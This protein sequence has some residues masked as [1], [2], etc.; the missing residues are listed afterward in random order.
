MKHPLKAYLISVFL[1]FGL[2]PHNVRAA[3]EGKAPPAPPEKPPLKIY[4]GFPFKKGEI[5][6]MEVTYFGANAGYVE[7]RVL[8][9]AFLGGRWMMGFSALVETGSWYEKIFKAR[10]EGIAYANASSFMPYQFR[11]TQ[12]NEQLIGKGYKEDKMIRFNFETC[13]VKEDYRTNQGNVTKTIKASLDTDS[14]DFVS[15]VYKLRTFDF[16]KKKEVR[17]KVYTSEKNWWLT[18]TKEAVEQI[19]VPYGKFDAVKLN[20]QTFIGKELQ[21]K[22]K[23]KIWLGLKEPKQVLRV[24]AEIKIGSFIGVLKNFYPGK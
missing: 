9:P 10:D 21:Q 7:L 2:F 15:A 4:E 13:E 5:H 14:L 18:A 22:G 20:M 3:C 8:P 16:T 1:S 12:D 11:M 17:M 23:A 6:T 19:E 24:E